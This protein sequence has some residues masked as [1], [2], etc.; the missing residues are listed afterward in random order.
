MKTD[1]NTHVHFDRSID[2]G[3]HYML[4]ADSVIIFD[5]YWA[6]NLKTLSR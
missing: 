5:K 4:D 2:D 1:K 6:E 3:N